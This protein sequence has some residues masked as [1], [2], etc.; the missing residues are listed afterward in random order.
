LSISS[1]LS[2]E[3]E[4]LFTLLPFTLSH[5]NWHEDPE[6]PAWTALKC[7]FVDGLNSALVPF[8][9]VVKTVENDP[10]AEHELE[11]A[12]DRLVR[13]LV[14]VS[15]LR[16]WVFPSANPMT[17]YQTAAAHAS[18]VQHGFVSE[19]ILEI[20]NSL[21]KRL[22]GPPP[23]KRKLYV[24]AFERMLLGESLGRVMNKLCD[25][26]SS[27]GHAKC[28]KRFQNGIGGV[29]ATLRKYAPGLVLE[30]D[31]LHPDRVLL[32]SHQ[33]SMTR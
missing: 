28:T 27:T 17:K 14:D 23:R 5:F 21:Q 18:L 20:C 15:E 2:Q 30:Y 3:I 1:P 11:E 24:D 22:V 32:K 9:R 10:A 6:H 29:K 13:A 12:I 31:K 8:L 16:A 19:H 7:A 26:G 25:C 33:K 4:K